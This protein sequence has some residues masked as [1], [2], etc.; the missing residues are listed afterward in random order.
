MKSLPMLNATATVYEIGV[1]LTD[2]ELYA[3]LETAKPVPGVVCPYLVFT[4][5]NT[6]RDILRQVYPCRRTLF[7]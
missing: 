5:G 1:T 4:S 7:L 6:T 2:S 3:I